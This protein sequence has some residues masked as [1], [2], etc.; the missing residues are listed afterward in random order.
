MRCKKK[1]KKQLEVKEGNVSSFFGP[2]YLMTNGRL[3]GHEPQ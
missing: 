2:L 1:N 3:Y